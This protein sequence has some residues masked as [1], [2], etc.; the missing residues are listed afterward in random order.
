MT[1]AP[2]NGVCW[3]CGHDH[4]VPMISPSSPDTTETELLR[5][6]DACREKNAEIE[7]LCS[8][9][10]R[11]DRQIMAWATKYGE[12]N[13]QWLPPAGD[14]DLLM[15][16]DDAL[17]VHNASLRGAEPAPPAERPSRSDS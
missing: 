3:H 13:P 8:L 6:M 12:H 17:M 11:C 16:I 9:L 4:S 2:I 14:A 1:Y 10:R 5:Y 7:R 15:D